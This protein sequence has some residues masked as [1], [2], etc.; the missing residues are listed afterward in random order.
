MTGSLR[1]LRNGDDD[2]PY[3]RAVV[4][5]D[6]GS[7]VAYRDVRRFG[8][9]LLLEPRGLRAVPR[10]QGRRRATRQ[11]AHGAIA[12]R[13]P[14]APARAPEGGRPRP[15]P[16]RRRREHLCGRGAVVGPPPPAAPGVRR[17]PT[18][19]E[20]LVRGIKRALRRG[21]ARQGATLRDYRR[22]RRRR[23][24]DADRVPGLRPRRRA[25][26][27]LR[28]RDREDPRRRSRNVVLPAVPGLSSRVLAA[29]N[30]TTL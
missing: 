23:R 18:E 12:R 4:K 8:T 10:D 21:I 5:L 24:R 14:R 2:D 9:W 7:D 13:P 22:R 16:L 20:A 15:A 28:P 17:Q 25:L 30:P 27:P 11:S 3:R 29:A 26:L 19:L 6:N 1:L